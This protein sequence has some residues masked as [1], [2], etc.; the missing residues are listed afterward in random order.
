MYHHIII[1]GGVSQKVPVE[2]IRGGRWDDKPFL[3]WHR[4]WV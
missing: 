4:S 1:I 3:R 2:I